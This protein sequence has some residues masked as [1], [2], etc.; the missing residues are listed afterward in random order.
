MHNSLIAQKTEA[1]VEHQRH[2]QGQEHKNPQRVHQYH[3]TDCVKNCTVNLQLDM[4][5]SVSCKAANSLLNHIADKS[6]I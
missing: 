5:C 4:F 3:A 2:S 6:N 1:V